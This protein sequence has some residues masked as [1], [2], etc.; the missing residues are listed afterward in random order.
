VPFVAIQLMMVALIAAF[1]QVVMHHKEADSAQ[2][3]TP[4]ELQIPAPELPQ[5]PGEL[6]STPAPQQDS[7]TN[8]QEIER[9][10]RQPR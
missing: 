5:T 6:Q 7:E 9:L 8:S 4:L 10:L 1:P 2:Q 3:K